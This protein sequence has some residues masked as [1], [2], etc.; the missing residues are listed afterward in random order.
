MCCGPGDL[1]PCLNLN[2]EPEHRELARM[3][4]SYRL[5]RIECVCH[6]VVLNECFTN[7][8]HVYSLSNL[9]PLLTWG[10]RQGAQRHL[11]RKGKVNMT[12]THM[13]QQL[14]QYFHLS[15]QSS[16]CPTTQVSIRGDDNLPR[17]IERKKYSEYTQNG[18]KNRN[19][20][21]QCL[22]N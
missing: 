16:L 15:L 22:E 13:G 7:C 5:L 10:L 12:T 11:S 20:M 6:L 8:G 17:N 9:V 3:L 1:M 4:T 18:H 2:I 19:I 14:E 21:P